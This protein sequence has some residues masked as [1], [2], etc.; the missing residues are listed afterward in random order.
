MSGGGIKA[1]GSG[2]AGTTASG[3]AAA[4]ADGRAAKVRRRVVSVPVVLVMFASVTAL[5]PVL[6][7][8]SLLVDAIRLA[9]RRTPPTIARL[10][11]MLEAY[12]VAQ[13]VGLCLLF[14]VWVAS[15][16][17][18]SP[19]RLAA[20]TF[21]VQQ[22]WAGWLMGCARSIFSLRIDLGD[23]SPAAQGPYVLAIRH[24]SIVDNLLPALAVS[25]PLG[26]RLRYVLKR[27]LLVDPCFDVA[28]CRLPNHFVDRD[29]GDPQEIE[30]VRA[31][32][33]G[34]GGR[35]AVLIYP[36]GTRA[37]P[38]KRKRALERIAE[39]NPARA[40]ALADLGHSLPPR[41]GGIVAL[42]EGA[43]EADVVVMVHA[44][45]D[46]LRGVAEVLDGGLVRVPIAIR[47]VRVPRRDIP[48]GG[49]SEWLDAL[50]LR[51]DSWVA[52]ALDAHA[53]G[54]PVPDFELRSGILI[55]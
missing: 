35:D 10:I 15:G 55:P 50:W 54:Q 20:M 5:L 52:A 27:E 3:R 45:L 18:G 2:G 7:A 16:F 6:L 26:I 33:G 12:L 31:I 47:L 25:R 19:R 40:E 46:G 51:I 37:T 9:L 32:S 29:S 17:G 48:A 14:G 44:G 13:A 49:E 30:R 8:I 1:S 43:P 34:M 41:P 39:R 38:A 42:L 28:G 53:S 4:A 11:L 23:N 22:A 21:A 36:E 24:T